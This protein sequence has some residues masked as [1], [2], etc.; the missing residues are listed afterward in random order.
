M[1]F[2]SFGVK[3]LTISLSDTHN[4]S[5]LQVSFSY[6]VNE[7]NFVASIANLLPQQE[8]QSFV[9]LSAGTAR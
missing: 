8:L 2:L 4:N 6:K 5:T 3:G 7:A 9:F 1:Y